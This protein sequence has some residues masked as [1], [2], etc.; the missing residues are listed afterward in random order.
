MTSPN[1]LHADFSISLHRELK[2]KYLH[3]RAQVIWLTGLSGAG[4]T[5]LAKGLEKELFTLGFFTQLLDGDNIRTGINNNLGF[6]DQD[7]LENIRRIAEVSKLFLHGGIITINSFISPTEEIRRLAKTIIGA[8][9]FIEIYVNASLEVCEKR[10]V[11][12]LYSKARR[13]EIKEFTGID[14]PFEI[15][16]EADVEVLTELES[17]A[18]SVH[19]VM[20]FILPRIALPLT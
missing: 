9:D 6:S 16:A 19:K 20:Q 3:Q 12:G 5:T 1:N 11:K 14:A 10:D 15:P 8:D 2:E 13:G 4:K 7:R 18:E 17:V